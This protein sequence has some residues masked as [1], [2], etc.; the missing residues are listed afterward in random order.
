M[1]ITDVLSTTKDTV[2]NV[3]D[4]VVKFGG[5]TIRWLTDNTTWLA[6]KAGQAFVRDLIV[7]PDFKHYSLVSCSFEFGAEC[8]KNERYLYRK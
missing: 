7:G 1:N 5:R 8:Q 2:F 4:A 3:I 6:G